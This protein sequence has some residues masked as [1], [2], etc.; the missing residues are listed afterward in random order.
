[1]R[2][3]SFFAGV[4]LLAAFVFA[5]SAKAG[6]PQGPRPILVELFTSQGCS[7]C[8]AADRIVGELA[9]RKDVIAL[10]L[11][12]TYWDML[13]WKDTLATEANTNRQK[14]Y[15]KA[16][17]RRGIYTP[18]IIIDGQ[19][20]VV[21]NQRDR[22]LAAVANRALETAYDQPVNLTLGIASGRVE[23]AIPAVGRRKTR[24]LATIWVMRTLSQATVS[25]QQGE[26]RNRQLSYANVVRELHRAGEWTGDAMKLDLPLTLGKSKQDGIAVILQSQ[27]YGQVLGA[28]LIEVPSNDL[29]AAPR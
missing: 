12:I 3:G 23:I 28:A 17:H 9:K 2:L 26:N 13:G 8:P 14:S 20:D 5:D 19:L 24:P 15:A 22:V 1:M 7:D 21:G 29:V 27:D 11:P 10:S 4:F 6:Q 16:M 25:V 18:Q